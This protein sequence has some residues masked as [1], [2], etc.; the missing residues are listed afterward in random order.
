MELFQA[1]LSIFAER[2]TFFLQLLV[3]HLWISGAAIGIAVVLGGAAGILIHRYERAAAPM[4]GTVNFLYTIP[5]ISMLGFLIP[6]FFL[7][8]PVLL[9]GSKSAPLAMTLWSVFTASVGTATLVAGLEGW[10][11]RRATLLGR[12]ALIAIAPLLLYA[13]VVSDAIGFAL[14]AAVSVYQYVKN[15]NRNAKKLAQKKENTDTAR[16]A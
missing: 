8:N 3:E 2:S 4:L 7:A 11:L 9:I 15:Q 6:F 16:N 1:V 5:S 14:L 10:L 12:T 13:G